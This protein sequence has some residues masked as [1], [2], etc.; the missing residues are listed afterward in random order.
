MTQI[1]NDESLPNAT[2]DHFEDWCEDANSGLPGVEFLIKL[3]TV[4]DRYV[5]DQLDGRSTPGVSNR[6]QAVPEVVP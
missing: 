1:M 2:G 5:A 4:L 3:D 6:Q